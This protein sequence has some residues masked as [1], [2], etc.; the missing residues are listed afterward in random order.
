MTDAF[1]Y[2]G[3]CHSMFEEKDPVIIDLDDPN[4]Q[5]Q[6]CQ[7]LDVF[8]LENRGYAMLLKMSE[9]G[10]ETL[11]IVQIVQNGRQADFQTIEAE[12]EFQRVVLHIEMQIRRHGN[13]ADRL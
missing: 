2:R 1:F 11:L 8:K 6:P 13:D 10:S 7:L 9:P 12:D 3:E 5:V 4:G